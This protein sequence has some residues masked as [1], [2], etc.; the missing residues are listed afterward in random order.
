MSFGR[1]RPSW[2][3]VG[4]VVPEE[5]WALLLEGEAVDGDIFVVDEEV[6]VVV[7]MEGATVGTMMPAL[8]SFFGLGILR[9]G[10]EEIKRGWV[11][12]RKIGLG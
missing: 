7:V 1:G 5:G 2:S 8:E 6:V 3:Q 11:R 12:L 10:G 4:G 9:K